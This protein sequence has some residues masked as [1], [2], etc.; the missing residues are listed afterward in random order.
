MRQTEKSLY[1]S[2]CS[3]SKVGNVQSI[4]ITNKN[5]NPTQGG[6]VVFE[7]NAKSQHV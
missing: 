7:I 6:M 3:N 2:S 5:L 4:T 1:L